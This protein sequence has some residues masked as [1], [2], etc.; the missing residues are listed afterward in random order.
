M[1]VGAE[2]LEGI[3][4]S[5]SEDGENYGAVVAANEVEAAFVLNEFWGERHW[6]KLSAGPALACAIRSIH[7]IGNEIKRKLNS[8]E[9]KCDLQ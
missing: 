3:V 4:E 2:L 7:R 9:K 6:L 1:A 8:C 5:R